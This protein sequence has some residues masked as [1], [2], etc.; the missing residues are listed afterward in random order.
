MIEDDI[1]LIEVIMS[2]WI[3]SWTHIV[4]KCSRG[5]VYITY[6]GVIDQS[7]SIIQP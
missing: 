7:N 4:I 3:I 6:E 5:V 1:Y 2:I